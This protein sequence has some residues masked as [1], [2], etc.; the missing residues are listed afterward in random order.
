LK[1]VKKK[2][3]IIEGKAIVISWRSDQIACP[4]FQILLSKKKKMQFY[5]F[6]MF[7]AI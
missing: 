5:L 1:N 2:A 4:E 6:K 3:W 7:V